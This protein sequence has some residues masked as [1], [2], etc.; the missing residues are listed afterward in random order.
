VTRQAVPLVGIALL[1]M[2]AFAL[3]VAIMLRPWASPDNSSNTH[4]NLT[5]VPY[6][7]YTRSPQSLVSPEGFAPIGVWRA[8]RCGGETSSVSD[9]QS[10]TLIQDL[11][12]GLAGDTDS[13]SCDDP[14]L[15]EWV[16]HGCANC[17]GLKGLGG[18]AGSNVL[19]ATL[20]DILDNVRFGPTGMP[21]FDALDLTDEHI[22]LLA[23]YV[24]EMRVANPESVPKPTIAPVPTA[25]PEPQVPVATPSPTP[26]DSSGSDLL[27]Q[28]KLLYEV[29]SGTEGCA[30]C[31]GLDGRG[32]GTSGETAPD[33]RGTSISQTR[34]AIR[35]TLEMKDIKLSKEELAAVAAYLQ[36]LYEQP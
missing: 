18:V 7:N 3:I 23:D 34:Q 31:H 24:E 12:S 13:S 10:I 29:T 32:V 15:T 8:P 28:G 6:S 25:T 33:I 26:A 35:G 2:M 4:L 36:F 30:Y 16:V 22:A 11:L 17:H 20:D 9:P 21:A 14:A 19:A 1:L 5:D 27:T